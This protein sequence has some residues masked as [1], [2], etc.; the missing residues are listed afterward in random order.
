MLRIFEKRRLKE[1]TDLVF[2]LESGQILSAIISLKNEKPPHFLFTNREIISHKHDL[3]EERLTSLMLSGLKNTAE[4]MSKKGFMEA[5]GKM[6]TKKNIHIFL[7]LPWYTSI[8]NEVTITKE[9]P[10]L[11]GENFISE[12][13]QEHFHI[14]NAKLIPLEQKIIS[15]KANGYHLEYPVGKKAKT[16]DIKSIVNA[17]SENL[18]KNIEE[19]VHLSFHDANIVFHTTTQA[20]F[21]VAS[22]LI[23][24]EQKKDFLLIIPEHDISEIILSKNG[25]FESTISLPFGKYSPVRMI[26]ALF[27]KEKIVTTSVL[28]LYM[29]KALSDEKTKEIE[30]LLKISKD[31]FQE[32]FKEALWKLS[33]TVLLPKDIVIADKSLVAKLIGEWI[34]TETWSSSVFGGGKLNI[35]FLGNVDLIDKIKKENELH[36]FEPILISC[37]LYLR[38]I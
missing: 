29:E 1:E 35:Y 26:S 21:P 31:K 20:M 24:K 28:K 17:S 6:H 33:P 37:G 25:M 7:G 9:K 15:V 8:S 38:A 23:N 4:I 12:S 11:I 30:G 19:I 14:S 16:I 36:Y 2:I 27:K 10:F 13:A 22:E 34:Q 3:N 32:L 5:A 18:I